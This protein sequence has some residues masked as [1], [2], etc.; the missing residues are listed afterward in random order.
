MAE[1]RT[2]NELKGEETSQ[3]PWRLLS[4]G[5]LKLKIILK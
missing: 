2:P 1:R 5:S 4:L 3:K